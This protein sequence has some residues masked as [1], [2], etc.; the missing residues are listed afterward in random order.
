MEAAASNVGQ[1]RTFLRLSGLWDQC[2]GPGV[3]ICAGE[4]VQWNGLT[5]VRMSRVSG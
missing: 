5:F 2:R 1:V 4:W 3:G